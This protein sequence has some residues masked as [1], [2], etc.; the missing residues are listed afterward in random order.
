M[1]GQADSGHGEGGGHGDGDG[2]GHGDGGAHG[3]GS[4]HGSGAPQAPVGV[5]SEV[6]SFAV[7]GGSAADRA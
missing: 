6:W 4:G 3:H 7:A 2:G 1:G 5:S